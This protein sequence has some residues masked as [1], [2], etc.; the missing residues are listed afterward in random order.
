MKNLFFTGLLFAVA[1]AVGSTA[2]VYRGENSGIVF[3]AA[4]HCAGFEVRGAVGPFI[5]VDCR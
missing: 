4:G 1:L 5:D 3:A 2:T